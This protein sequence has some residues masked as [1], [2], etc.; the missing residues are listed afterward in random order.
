MRRE[1]ICTST[2]CPDFVDAAAGGVNLEALGDLVLRPVAV[3]DDAHGQNVV[4]LF[5]GDVLVLHLAPDA[6]GRLD[7]CLYLVVEASFVEALA[8]GCSELAEDLVQV[9]VHVCQLLSDGAVFV[10][11]FVTETEV[12]KFFLHLV[13]AEAMC[14]W[15]IDVERLAG[16]LVLLAG[17]LAAKGAHVMEAVGN[18]DEDDA[19]VVAHGKEELLEGLGLCGRLVSEDSARDFGQPVHDFGNLGAEDVLY[20]LYRIVCVLHYIMQQRGADAGAAQSDFL[21]GYLRHGYGVHDIRLARETAHSLVCLP[22][23]VVG[24]LDDFD[25]LA[26]A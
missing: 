19:D 23:K 22:R 11:V 15:C 13:Q 1:R 21:A 18:L 12:L 17:Q 3:E 8:D 4:Y 16:N 25:V 14:Q 10:G 20:V 6:V 7:A 2:H 9:G 24:L 5:E 26:V